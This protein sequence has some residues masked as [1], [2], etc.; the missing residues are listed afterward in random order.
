MDGL[1][2]LF[3]NESVLLHLDGTR[4]T[5]RVI[6]Q[7]GTGIIIQQG[8]YALK[9]PRISR[10]TKID[11]VAVEV[12][13]LTP[14]EGNYDERAPLI[15]SIEVEKAIYK[16]LGDHGGIVH[17]HNLEST[18]VSIQMDL[19]NGDLRHY[20]AQNRPERKTQLSWLTK[21]AHTMAYIHQNRIIIAD[22]RL[23]NLLLDDDLTVKFCDFGESTLMPLDWDLDGTDDL[24]FSVLTDIGQFAAVMY[25]VITG[26][27]CKF[28]LSLDRKEPDNLYVCPRRDRLPST[29]SIW[30]GHVI[31]KCWTQ[32]FTSAKELAAELDQERVPE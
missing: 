30:L 12:G 3:S 1:S 8:Q 28:D 19:M 17:C 11:G 2:S 16:R 24:G 26:L 25:E 5:E 14:E 21:M 29:D 32:A 13:R 27:K 10:H 7:G 6:G 20:L 15:E 31:D 9:L 4:V 22:I 18:G 23:D